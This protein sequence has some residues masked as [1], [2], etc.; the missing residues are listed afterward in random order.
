VKAL[1]PPAHV[2]ELISLVMEAIFVAYTIYLALVRDWPGRRL[3]FA[4]TGLA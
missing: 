1:H 4:E 3:V 2:H